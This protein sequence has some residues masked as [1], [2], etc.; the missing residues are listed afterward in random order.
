V[1]APARIRPA[2]DRYTGIVKHHLPGCKG[3]ELELRCSILLM[4]DQAGS[5]LRQCS[6]DA[7]GALSEVQRLATVYA[8]ASIPVEEL[9]ELRYRLLQLT[10]TASGLEM[11]A[12]RIA[13]PDGGANG[14]G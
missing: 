10:Q 1:N 3:E 7:A 6:E 9:K 11:F 5:S 4:R 2:R 8:Y 14:R 12:Y 13:Y